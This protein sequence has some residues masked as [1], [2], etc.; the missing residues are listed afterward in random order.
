MAILHH[1]VYKKVHGTKSFLA[2][3]R[4]YLRIMELELQKIDPSIMIPFWDWSRYSQAPEKDAVLTNRRFGFD[5]DKNTN[6]ISGG[7]FK[8][9]TVY[10][11]GDGK[12][13]EHCVRRKIQKMDKKAIT[14]LSSEVIDGVTLNKPDF[15]S[16]AS[17]IE[18]SHAYLHNFVGAD[19]CGHTS[20][21]DPLFYSHHAFIDKIW[22]D[23]SKRHPEKEY[24]YAFDNTIADMD[25]KL[26]KF[27]L[28]VRDVLN[29]AEKL[30]YIYPEDNFKY[31][32]NKNQTSTDKP[33]T[34]ATSSGSSTTLTS[35]STSTSTSN[36]KIETSGTSSTVIKSE[37]SSTQFETVPT[38]SKYS[39][40]VHNAIP[41]SEPEINNDEFSSDESSNQG[42]LI[43]RVD[44]LMIISSKSSYDILSSDVEEFVEVECDEEK[45]LT[46][47]VTEYVMKGV[48][49][50]KVS[51]RQDMEQIRV[52]P[53]FSEEFLLMMNY[54]IVEVRK[55][56]R[57]N[58]LY[59]SKLNEERKNNPLRCALGNLDS[60]PKLPEP[61]KRKCHKKKGSSTKE[62]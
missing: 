36:I 50:P 42:H 45:E 29:P 31:D 58:A 7:S 2:W 55:Y 39:K 35:T 12:S 24:T 38:Y 18:I 54:N 10:Y 5:G 25:S 60:F 22:F 17:N 40:V 13:Q 43:R 57:L 48:T 30:C 32:V 23:W 56:E 21:N 46:D 6:C 14:L 1:E 26:Y 8:N 28:S 51:D 19:F 61:S 3:H 34:S 27:D 52:P 49:A 33:V 59:I 4:V 15:S 20:P 11:E 44:D 9:T 37:V 62:N 41:T 16:F 47:Y 53:V